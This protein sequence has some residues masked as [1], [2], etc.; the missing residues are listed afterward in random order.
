MMKVE[1]KRHFMF[2]MRIIMKGNMSN[3]YQL[4]LHCTLVCA[5]FFLQ[6]VFVPVR[7]KDLISRINVTQVSFCRTTE[8]RY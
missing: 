5:V 1:H 6:E 8:K 4:W 7:I 2:L 3:I